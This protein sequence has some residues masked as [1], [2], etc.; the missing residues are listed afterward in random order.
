MVVDGCTC[1]GQVGLHDVVGQLAGQVELEGG[2]ADS[3]HGNTP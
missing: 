2:L 1:G 3:S